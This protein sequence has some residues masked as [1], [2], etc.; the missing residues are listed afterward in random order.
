MRNLTIKQIKWL[1]A[2]L[3]H[4]NAT[5]AARDAGYRCGSENAFGLVGHENIQKLKI[6]I[7]KYLD[8][9]ELS[10]GAIK[11]KIIQGMTATETKFWAYE[12]KVTDQ[13]EV[14]ALGIQA[15]YCELAARVRGLLDTEIGRRLDELEKKVDEVRSSQ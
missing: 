10:D 3:E 1:N 6:H 9:L 4:G 13:R 2:Y 7:E 12:G 15:R 11:L 14:E 5:Q 8:E